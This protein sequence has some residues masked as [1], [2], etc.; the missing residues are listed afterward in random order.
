METGALAASHLIVYVADTDGTSVG[1][2][3]SVL[4]INSR[5]QAR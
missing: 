5:P 4:K 1:L 2:T 3:L